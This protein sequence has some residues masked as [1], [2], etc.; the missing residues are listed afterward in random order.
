MSVE[1]G[2][3]SGKFPDEVIVALHEAAITATCMP[4][5][6][7]DADWQAAFFYVLAPD[8]ACLTAGRL[9][10][11]PFSVAL[12]A[13]LHEHENGSMIEIGFEIITPI[14]PCKGVLLFLTGHTS[15]HFDA[16][17][18]LSNQNDIP[19]FIGD[20]FCNNLWQQRI[21]MNP[22]YQSGLSGLID[23]A[24]ARD[25]VIRMTG[26]YD[27]DAVFADTLAKQQIA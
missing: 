17:K 5:R 20:Q 21:P 19:L 18:L 4:V 22:A 3:P 12:D 16:L 10:G 7:D 8:A 26:Q 2:Q 14:E 6:L 25:A 23:E 24:V 27:P 15:T 9:L 11:G 13:D 1:S